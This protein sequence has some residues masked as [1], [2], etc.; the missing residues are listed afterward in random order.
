MRLVAYNNLNL[1]HL[2]EVKVVVC[3][4]N[5]NADEEDAYFGVSYCIVGFGLE[6]QLG[7]FICY[8]LGPIWIWKWT[9]PGNACGKYL[10]SHE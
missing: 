6:F 4:K 8:K 5:D 2:Q 10:W 7:Q 1:S 3:Q 9:E